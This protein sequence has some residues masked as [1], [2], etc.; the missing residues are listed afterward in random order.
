MV[1]Q[2]VRS[3][4]ICSIG[5]DPTLMILEVEFIGTGRRRNTVYQFFRVPT[6]IHAAL[7]SAGSHGQYFNR[8]VKAR[9]RYW[10]V[11]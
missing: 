1:R 3:S 2:P 5:Y 9:Y 8:Q 6:S 4:N 11:A 7:M 10:R